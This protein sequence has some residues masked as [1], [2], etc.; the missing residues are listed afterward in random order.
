MKVLFSLFR[1]MRPYKKEFIL[2]VVL[3]AL[4]TSFELFIPKVM[5]D[6]IDEGIM[7]GDIEYILTQGVII[8][9]AAVASLVLGLLY[10]RYSARAI[11]GF[12]SELR[13]A[14][15]TKIQ[16]YSFK[17]IDHFETSS[18]ITRLTSDVTVIQNAL[19]NLRPMSR[20]PIMLVVG[21][22]FSFMMSPELALV[23]VVATPVLAFILFL[24]IYKVS[25]LYSKLQEK[26]DR[27][28]IVIE[29][30]LGA[31]R[32][33]KAYVRKDYEQAHFD[34]VN[35]DLQ[36]S[37]KKTFSIAMLNMP[38]FQ[39]T[40]YAVIVMIMFLGGELIFAG[41]M[42]VGA[43]TGLLSYVLQIMN[44]LMMMS[45]IFL[46]MTRSLASA[47]RVV[48]I[49]DEPIDLK[50]G[51]YDRP[52]EKGAI[53]FEDVYFKYADDAKEYVL[54]DIDLHIKEGETIGI[55]G[56]TG[57]AKSTL[58]S[59][60]PRLYDVT[61]GRIL[62]DG[63]D[64]KAYDLKALRKKIAIVLQKNL[65]FS[66]TIRENMLWGDDGASDQKIDEALKVAGAYD[67][68][69]S[70]KDGLDTYL[71]EGGVNVSGGQRQRLCIARAL[72]KDP[73][74]LILDDSTSAVDMETERSIRK[75]LSAITDMTKIII[76]QRV[77]SVM[78][79]DKIVILDDG[80]IEAIGDHKALLEKSLIY[81][82]LYEV[83]M[84]GVQDA[85]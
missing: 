8:I 49:F 77:V 71:E 44:S 30:G 51:S 55:L 59:L 69:Y 6:I 17:N 70:F 34:E 60:I 2:A 74:I 9:L 25:P 67:F 65:L 43:L 39:F 61:S 47:R 75:A 64:V 15:F 63:R 23:F 7:S 19:T 4:E 42:Q 3:V 57:S 10:A 36:E 27:L 18:F 76:A 83:Q 79:A 58:V 78:E 54:E 14:E 24:I 46:M 29:E 84:K 38:A 72:L 12:G 33:I 40:M 52:I 62:V 32:I 53:T 48:E 50:S 13:K 68:V 80:K 35:D 20:A 82:D 16:E 56:A 31:I 66:G 85:A 11:H 5:A 41:K 73:K 45:N 26:L 21:I 37:A 1:F 22:L 81:R 28:N